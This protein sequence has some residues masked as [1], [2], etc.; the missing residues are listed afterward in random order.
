[1][2]LEQRVVEMIKKKKKIGEKQF[3]GDGLHTLPYWKTFMET[4]AP[5]IQ[6]K[7]NK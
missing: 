2:E 6:R 1:M 5:S 4:A 3:Y 7:K